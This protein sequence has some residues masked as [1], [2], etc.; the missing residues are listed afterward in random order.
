M[1]MRIVMSCIRARVYGFGVRGKGPFGSNQTYR[2]VADD[3]PLPPANTFK[4][5]ET[6]FGS[7]TTVVLVSET[8]YGY[9]VRPTCNH[10]RLQFEDYF[11]FGLS[12]Q[13]Y[14]PHRVIFVPK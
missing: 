4:P 9:Y 11:G 12:N 13:G 14:T 2:V 6:Y 7:T 8:K 1:S 10:Y 5:V 3:C